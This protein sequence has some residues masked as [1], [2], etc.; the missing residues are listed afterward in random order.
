MDTF[1]VSQFEAAADPR[2]QA[3][4]DQLGEFERQKTNLGRE[5]QADLAR[6]HQ[7]TAALQD[8]DLQ[9]VLGKARAV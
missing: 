8:L 3:L 9:I 4:N 7:A 1:D 5:R 6:L 2:I